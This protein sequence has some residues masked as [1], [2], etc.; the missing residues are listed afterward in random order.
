MRGC[1]MADKIMDGG[2]GALPLVNA[3]TPAA[4]FENAI[5]EFGVINACEWFG[6]ASDSEFTLETVRVLR[7][8][9]NGNG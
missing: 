9:E 6:Y 7:A 8:R 3:P 1:A 5:R 4:R 2:P